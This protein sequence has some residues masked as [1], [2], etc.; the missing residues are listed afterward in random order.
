MSWV[1]IVALVIFVLGAG[2]L[3]LVALW[4]RIALEDHHYSVKNRN[5]RL[6]GGIR[7]GGKIGRF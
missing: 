6:H 7:G 5:G 2:F 1:S 4:A 3:M